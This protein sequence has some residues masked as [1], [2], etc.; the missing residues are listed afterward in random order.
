MP[1]IYRVTFEG[2]SV[3]APQDLIQIN[4]AA[5]KMVRIIRAWLGNTDTT[6]AT[7]Q[8]LQLRSRYL[9]AT[10]SNGSG[11]SAPT[12]QK[13]DAGDAAASATALANNTSKATTNGTAA[14]LDEQGVHIYAGCDISYQNRP[15]VGPTDAFVFELLSTVTGTVHLSGGIEFE[16]MGGTA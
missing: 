5:G 10:V 3:S 1:R 12:P 7:A 14:I 9:P 6:L 2:V 11:G 8:M 4:G 16:E 13:L 15:V